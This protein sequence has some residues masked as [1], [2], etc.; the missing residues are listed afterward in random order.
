MVRLVWNAGAGDVASLA[1]WR[2]ECRPRLLCGLAFLCLLSIGIT[3]SARD[4]GQAGSYKLTVTGSFA[5]GST[6]L[7]HKTNLTLVVQ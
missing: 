5:S 4:G 6:M 3:M 7:T 1:S 2:R